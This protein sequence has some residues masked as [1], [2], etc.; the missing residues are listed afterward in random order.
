MEVSITGKNIDITEGLRLHAA[1][2]A[3]RLGRLLREGTSVRI[4]AGVQK[5]VQVAEISIHLDS[6]AFRAEARSNDMYQ[7]L[8]AAFAK[9]RR[10]VVKLKDRWQSHPR[11]E[12]EAKSAR[13][14]GTALAELQERFEPPITVNKAYPRKPMT[15][16][17]ACMQLE[18][19]GADFL[20]FVNAATGQVHVIYHAGQDHYGMIS[21]EG[22]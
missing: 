20:P 2:K 15:V 21:P 10:Q 6:F 4:V 5:G 17:E 7:S 1:K 12:S 13:L 19:R 3:S 16:E 11:Q 18:L 9:L 22:A 14:S 8:D